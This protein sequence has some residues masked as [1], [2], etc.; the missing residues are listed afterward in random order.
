[1]TV[2]EYVLAHKDEYTHGLV[3]IGQK[4]NNKTFSRAIVQED[5]D[6]FIIG[7]KKRI[8]TYKFNTDKVKYKYTLLIIN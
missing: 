3:M 4:K 7:S 8:G 2:R 6:C 5:M 1:M